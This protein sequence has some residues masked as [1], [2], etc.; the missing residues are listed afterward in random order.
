MHAGNIFWGLGC[1]KNL[2]V[3]C[4]DFSLLYIVISLFNKI[5]SENTHDRY[6]SHDAEESLACTRERGKCACRKYIF[7][8]WVVLR[9]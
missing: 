1:T 4:S 2:I 9:V 8:G 3:L 6:T 5:F 7:G